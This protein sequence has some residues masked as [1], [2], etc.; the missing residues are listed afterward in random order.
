MQTLSPSDFSFH[1]ALRR[2]DGGLAF[3]DFEYFGWD[4]PVKLVSDFLWHPAMTLSAAQASRF[5]RGAHELFAAQDATYGSRLR[6]YFPLFGLKWCTIMLNEFVA[7]DW[8]RRQFAGQQRKRERVKAEQL[9]KSR[10]LCEEV[11][12]R[13]R[14]VVLW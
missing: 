12:T 13:T 3:L 14:E 6:A 4:D 7:D 9:H 5:A 2:A 8:N 10:A 1:N 11:L